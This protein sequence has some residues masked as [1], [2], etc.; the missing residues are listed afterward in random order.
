M[1]K[2]YN[3]LKILSWNAKG[4]RNK[5]DKLQALLSSVSAKIV[6]INELKLNPS[7]KIKFHHVHIYHMNNHSWVRSIAHGGTVVLV[8]HRIVEL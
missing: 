2:T 7:I 3:P 1:L 8:H 6:L 4:I 5:D